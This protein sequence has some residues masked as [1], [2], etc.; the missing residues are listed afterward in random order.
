[1]LIG[2]L[3]CSNPCGSAF[4]SLSS[5]TDHGASNKHPSFWTFEGTC[6]VCSK[7]VKAMRGIYCA[8]SHTYR[9]GWTPCLSIWHVECYTCLGQDRW[10]FPIAE[11]KDGDGNVWRPD[12]GRMKRFNQGAEG[13]HLCSLFP[14]ELCWF[15]NLEGRDPL[16]GV[17][18]QA[19]C[20]I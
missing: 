8:N 14:C 20:L 1:M 4:S 7:P 10:K 17:H 11:V 12:G 19:I 6:V 16:P 2:R 5:N 3:A 9:G 13:A 18:D 15:R